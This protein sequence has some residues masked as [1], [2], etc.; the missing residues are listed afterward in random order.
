MH[1]RPR[2]PRPR[3]AFTLIELLVVISIIA[4]LIAILLPA[5]GAARSSAQLAVCKS[6]MKQWGI[7]FT[8]YAAEN[9]GLLP[10]EGVT[11]F[12]GGAQ[13]DKEQR[14][15]FNAM[16]SYIDVPE[17]SD[18]YGR[19]GQGYSQDTSVWF[20]PS[21]LKRY[22]NEKNANGNNFHYGWNSVLDGT[23]QYGPFDNSGKVIQLRS[24]QISQGSSTLIL[25][26]PHNRVPNIVPQSD[27]ADGPKSN[28]KL[29]DGRHA[30]EV[31]NFV[32]FD[33]HV[34]SFGEEESATISSGS[35]N[36]LWKTADDDLV[37]GSYLR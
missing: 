30:N 16:P 26:E 9:K 3:R 2:Q 33:G 19:F 8:G 22:G 4:L 6:N 24:V 32:F 15:W 11:S 21:Q 17:Y 14:R 1:H 36:E 18:V 27:L 10:A 29:D 34:E 23:S 28:E 35:N 37:W 12:P 20:C 13:A 5:L 31:L 25:G 7:A